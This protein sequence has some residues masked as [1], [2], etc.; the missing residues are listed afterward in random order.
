[1]ENFTLCAVNLFINFPFF[2][3]KESMP[4]LAAP[5]GA[6]DAI[7]MIAFD[8][9]HQLML[10]K[11]VRNIGIWVIQNGINQLYLNL[12]T[13]YCYLN[14]NNLKWNENF[15]SKSNYMQS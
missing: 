2:Y 12:K 9:C 14:Q 11:L 15:L 10:K 6:Y 1:M 8:K 7:L 3:L 13:L 5:G 4:I